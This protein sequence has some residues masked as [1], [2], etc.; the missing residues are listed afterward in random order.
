MNDS[1]V[2]QLIKDAMVELFELDP[3]DVVLDAHIVDDL[4]L[5]SIDAVDLIVH[6]Q[7]QTDIKIKPEEFKSV[8][9]VEDI[10]AVVLSL[11]ETA[12]A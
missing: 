7:R 3:N 5:D 8:R 2:F 4:E 6:L 10:V 11:V 9:R 1:Q 12:E